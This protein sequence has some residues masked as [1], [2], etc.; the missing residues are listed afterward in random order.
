MRTAI[1]VYQPTLIN[2]STSESGLQLCSMNADTVP[3]SEGDNAQTIAPGIYKIVSSQDIVITGD[4]SAFD[5][6]TTDSKDNDP[7]PPLRA[8]SSFAPLDAAALQAFLAVPDAKIV[9]NP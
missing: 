8:T 9:V 6:I 2:I 7:T 4:T 3:L 5:A 1:F